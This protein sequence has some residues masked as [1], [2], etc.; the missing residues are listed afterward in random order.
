VNRY[1]TFIR[2]WQQ[3]FVDS[4]GGDCGDNYDNLVQASEYLHRDQN[5]LIREYNTARTIR[6]VTIGAGAAETY[7]RSSLID[8]QDYFDLDNP[9]DVQ[10][11]DDLRCG[12]EE[13]PLSLQEIVT[14]T[15]SARLM[16]LAED[17]NR[18]PSL[19][20][21]SFN[22]YEAAHSAINDIYWAARITLTR[23]RDEIERLNQAWANSSIFN[24]IP[25]SGFIENA[26][27]AF[28][29]FMVMGVSLCRARREVCSSD[30]LYEYFVDNFDVVTALASTKRKDNGF[31]FHYGARVLAGDPGVLGEN[32]LLAKKE[33]GAYRSHWNRSIVHQAV[34][35][36]PGH[37]PAATQNRIRPR[38]RAEVDAVAKCLGNAGL[39]DYIVDGS[40]ST[41]QLF[42]ARVLPKFAQTIFQNTEWQELFLKNYSQ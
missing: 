23:D 8:Q 2:D 20:S 24:Y 33:G 15:A 40:V 6:A 19:I 16:L 18:E 21:T 11:T 12:F 42:V 37:C 13:L 1:T 9:A 22:F 3:R 14:D 41:G 27:A 38:N 39:G 26:S 10:I 4:R 5:S 25:F 29:L 32:Y 35:N 31:R 7:F 30:D 28:D 17:N 34:L 36:N